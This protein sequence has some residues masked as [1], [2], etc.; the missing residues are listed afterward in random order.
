MK[1]IIAILP[2][3]SLA[4]ASPLDIYVH[5]ESNTVQ[6]GLHTRQDICWRACFPSEPECPEGLVNTRSPFHF[7]PFLNARLQLTFFLQFAKD[8]GGCWTCCIKSPKEQKEKEKPIDLLVESNAIQ[9]GPHAQVPLCWAACFSS[10]PT[11]PENWVR[12]LHLRDSRSPSNSRH[13]YEAAAN[14]FSQYSEGEGGCWTCCF[15]PESAQHKEEKTIDIL[16]SAPHDEEKA[17]DSQIGS[18]AAR[19]GYGYGAQGL[20]CT[21]YGSEKELSCTA[22]WVRTCI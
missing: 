11:C 8:D 10:E 13:Y 1:S 9:S 12:K 7:A 4:V 17:I 15:K 14:F 19:C 22:P 5:T 3:A 2:L 18:N 6:S 16:L 20:Q 21:A